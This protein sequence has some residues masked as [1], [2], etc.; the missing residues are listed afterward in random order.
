MPKLTFTTKELIPIIE[1]QLPDIINDLQPITKGF[2]FKFT[3]LPF[4]DILIKVK[5]NKFKGETA[6]FKIEPSILKYI[7]LLPDKYKNF[8]PDGAKLDDSN[9][10]VDIGYH[11][12]NMRIANMYICVS[13]IQIVDKSFQVDFLLSSLS[14]QFYSANDS[15][16]HSFCNFVD[17]NSHYNYCLKE[18][19]YHKNYYRF[20]SSDKKVSLGEINSNEHLEEL[21]NSSKKK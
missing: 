17:L 15:Y 4:K 6:Y 5:F 20:F 19:A 2:T 1:T 9:L 7:Y 13:D 3:G 14:V 16:I 11:L 10:S 21:W 8:L 12:R 18:K